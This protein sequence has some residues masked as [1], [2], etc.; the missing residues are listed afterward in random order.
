MGEH[1]DIFHAKEL[2]INYSQCVVH[3]DSLP[4]K[5]PKSTV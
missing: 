1:R 3:G 4:K 2:Q 5:I